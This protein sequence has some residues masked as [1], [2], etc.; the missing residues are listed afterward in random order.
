MTEGEG[1]GGGWADVAGVK[2]VNIIVLKER[3][4]KGR[5]WAYALYLILTKTTTMVK[6]S[7]LHYKPQAD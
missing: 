7:G 3:C 1:G 6:A 5:G 2:R 4:N